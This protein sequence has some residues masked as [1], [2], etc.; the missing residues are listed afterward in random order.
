MPG[1]GSS[2]EWGVRFNGYRVIIVEEEKVLKMDNGDGYIAMRI[3][4]MLLNCALKNGCGKFYVMYVIP[5]LKK[6][7]KDLPST[8]SCASL[9]KRFQAHRKE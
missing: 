3:Y 4:L 9:G 7:Q 5:Q 1:A 6:V 8:K 2:G